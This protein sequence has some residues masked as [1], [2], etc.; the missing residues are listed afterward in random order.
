MIAPSIITLVIETIIILLFGVIGFIL[1]R[2]FENYAILGYIFI[3]IIISPALWTHF[4]PGVLLITNRA[5][6]EFYAEIGIVLLIFSIGLEFSLDKMRAVGI[7][8]MIIGTLEMLLIFSI[9][10]LIFI[11][12]KFTLIES[13][14][15]SAVLSISSTT[16]VLRFTI[17]N[18]DKETFTKIISI[19]LIEDFGAILILT[20]LSGTTAW[21]L[22]S[23]FLMIINIG[24]IILIIYAVGIQIFPKII[25]YLYKRNNIH[26]AI[27]I[28][29]F[30]LF[31]FSFYLRVLEI[32]TAIAA[33]IFGIIIAESEAGHIIERKIRI[34][35][36]I[37]L[38][39]FFISIGMLIDVRL[40]FNINFL[41][42]ALGLSLFFMTMKTFAVT[43]S[44]LFTGERFRNAL[45]LGLSFPVLGEF[46]LVIAEYGYIHRGLANI[47]ALSIFTVLFTIIIYS[48]WCRICNVMF[49]IIE[50]K[51]PRLIILGLSYYRALLYDLRLRITSS[52][53]ISDDVKLRLKIILVDIVILMV[54]IYVFLAV[55]PLAPQ[56]A[57]YLG[58]TIE[59]TKIIIIILTLLFIISS[60]YSLIRNIMNLVELV[61]K[62]SIKSWPPTMLLGR[63]S[64][65]RIITESTV[66]LIILFLIIISAPVLLTTPSFIDVGIY[67]IGS[68]IFICIFLIWD[69]LHLFHQRVQKTF[70]HIIIGEKK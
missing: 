3:G 8:A 15:L 63:K 1:F 25:N 9:S 27:I 2:K 53:R 10:Y 65:T 57:V 48:F 20:V 70:Y 40:F 31:L 42:I 32:S 7:V 6:V 67:I 47:L 21:D 22:Q 17:K 23:L 19:L 44:T 69:S 55:Y 56:I 30:C 33:F 50:Q 54:V 49:S 18:V 4:F 43:V 64:V 34:F 62:Y 58:L 46:S 51:A 35:K 37:F 16:I 5:L 14:Y 66:G 60:G 45:L 68:M 39:I 12:L 28:T 59:H 26:L 24:L 11:H 13:I 41:V 38:I 61:T 52:Q 29:L 36:E